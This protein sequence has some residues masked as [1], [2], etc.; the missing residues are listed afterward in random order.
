MSD[1]IEQDPNELLLVLA[2]VK[3]SVE[4]LTKQKSDIE[5]RLIILLEANDKKTL[6][7]SSADGRKVTGTLV[8]A[9]RVHIDAE[10]LEKILP[11]DLWTKVTRRVLDSGLLE[12]HITTGV[13]NE[14]TVASVTEVKQNKPYVR[15]S[16]DLPTIT[17]LEQVQTMSEGGREK[18]AVKRV[19]AKKAAKAAGPA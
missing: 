11:A 4:M 15:I 1:D 7:A 19:K 5:A 9:E 13:I 3:A 17:G 2:S 12:A 16:G 14:Q 8:R 18:A 6:T 10:A